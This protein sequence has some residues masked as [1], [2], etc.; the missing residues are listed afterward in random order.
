MIVRARLATS[1]GEAAHRAPRSTSGRAASGWT[2]WTTS[3]SP[4]ASRWPAIGGPRLPVPTKR[5]ASLFMEA[6]YHRGVRAPRQAPAVTLGVL[7][8]GLAA[9]SW[10]TTGSVMIVVSGYAVSPL[11]VGTARLWIAA[12]LLVLAALLSGAPRG[13]PPSPG[14]PGADVRRPLRPGPPPRTPRRRPCGVR[15]CGRHPR[16]ARGGGRRGRRGGAP[17][18]LASGCSRRATRDAAVWR[19]YVAKRTGV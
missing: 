7:L 10:G 6:S 4:A 12:V 14:P 5:I 2:S 19:K 8:I 9:I 3:A 11:L 1:A 13:A 16:R 17:W 15:A 18:V